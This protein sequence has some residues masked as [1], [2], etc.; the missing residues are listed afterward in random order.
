M[1]CGGISQWPSDHRR[2]RIELGH[3]QER[4]KRQ[5]LDMLRARG[6]GCLGR[7]DVNV[8]LAQGHGMTDAATLF[9]RRR[10]REVGRV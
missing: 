7:R 8:G 4:H 9:I 10:P 2:Q 6:I 5:L 3:A 1:L